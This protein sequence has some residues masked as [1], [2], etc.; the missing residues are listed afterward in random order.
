MKNV[1]V[2]RLDNNKKI[3][4]TNTTTVEQALNKGGFTKGED[5]VMQDITGNEYDGDE[6]V[7]EGKAYFL[8][9]RVKSGKNA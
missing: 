1:V 3:E 9:Q 8:V 7:E 4:V 2:G 5:E 6:R